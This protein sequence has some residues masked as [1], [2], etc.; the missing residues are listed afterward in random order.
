MHARMSAA[1]LAATA[2]PLLAGCND[3]WMTQRAY[4]SRPAD[5]APGTAPPEMIV[6]YPVYLIIGGAIDLGVAVHN[7]IRNRIRDGNDGIDWESDEGRRL[8][9]ASVS[10]ARTST[11]PVAAPRDGARP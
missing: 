7:G 6:L 11:Q 5:I 2:I 1:A 4:G 8:R 9:S 10:P 3:F